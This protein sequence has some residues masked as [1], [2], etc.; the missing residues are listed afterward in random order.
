MRH[1]RIRFTVR[2]L[3]VVVAVVFAFEVWATRFAFSLMGDTSLGFELGIVLLLLQS[4]L[5]L[6]YVCVYSTW[7]LVQLIRTRLRSRRS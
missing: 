4:L 7:F 5:M 6:A 2:G 1:P 3:M